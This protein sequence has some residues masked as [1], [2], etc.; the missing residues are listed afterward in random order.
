MTT[1][2]SIAFSVLA[3]LGFWGGPS[4]AQGLSWEINVGFS[5]AHKADAWTPIFV[6]IANTG[7][8]QQ[9]EVVIPVDRS[10]R[11][12][13]VVNYAIPVDAP[14]NSKKRYTLYLPSEGFDEAKLILTGG[15]RTRAIPPGP[16]AEPQD[17]LAVVIGGDKGLLSFLT[18]VKAYDLGDHGA[19]QDPFSQSVQ[20]E[21]EIMV[22]HA[23]WDRLP[24]SWLGWDGVDA[25][26]LGDAL[27]AGA[28]QEALDALLQWVR[29]GGCLIVGGG[30]RSQEIANSPISPLLPF[31]VT[32][33]K[34]LPDLAELGR[35]V[36]APIPAQPVLAVEGE[37]APEAEVLCGTQEQPLIAARRVGLGRVV[38]TAFDYTAAPVKYWNG[39]NLM[40]PLLLAR[41]ARPQS[42][43]EGRETPSRWQWGV[44]LAEAATYAPEGRL[45]PVWV[46]LTFLGA[47]VVVLV[48]ANHY[49][50]HRMGRRELAWLTTP[51]I[52]ALFA[53]FAYALGY[54]IRGGALV[55]NRLSVIETEA[56][57]GLARGR[58]YVGIF[59]PGRKT[60][61]FL[62]SGSAIGGR[63][64][65]PPGQKTHT[66]ASVYYG[67]LP[68]IADV[69]MNMWTSRA[70]G[71][72]F[73]AD[74][75]EGIG[76]TIEYDG[77]ALRAHVQNNTGFPLT[78]CRLVAGRSQ[79]VGKVDIMP[80][81]AAD[82]VLAKGAPVGPRGAY[83]RYRGAISEQ[84]EPKAAIVD[85]AL[86]AVFGDYYGMSTGGG[87]T[88]AADEVYVLALAEE[89]L[90]PVELSERTPRTN[91]VGIIFARL[92]TKLA[93]GKR[94]RVPRYLVSTQLIA[95]ENGL[96]YVG[97]DEEGIILREGTSVFE[98]RVPSGPAGGRATSLALRAPLSDPGSFVTQAPGPGAAPAP[99]GPAP[100][101]RLT[102]VFAYDFPRDR[103]VA[104]GRAVATS[105][106]AFPQPASAYMSADGR[107]LVKLT[108]TS[109]EARFDM[110]ALEA[111]VETFGGDAGD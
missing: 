16:T 70:F 27:F 29:L 106:L 19:V 2:R 40:W 32:G 57:A 111:E 69:R 47:Y 6:D 54:G 17:T 88:A 48:P 80:G 36:A 25:V 97:P 96:G 35:W 103:W 83:R 107:V 45:P 59:S 86:S 68:R 14:R 75:G 1:W 87:G 42:L 76:G 72:D 31:R 105:Q 8:S 41:T 44:T 92:P 74:V 12:E 53:V 9:G 67:A 50:L 28:S 66:P 102:E 34:T 18:G 78:Q 7:D 95:S 55:L 33:T 60:Y 104:I 89:P 82:L 46:I 30:A 22:G 101:P 56:D 79:G 5:G 71:V 77:A 73:L 91:D 49:L 4:H 3:L 51:V 98:F 63:D 94:M 39:Q 13:Q 81:E 43:T 85:L 11:Q 109:G 26:I 65:V 110:L 90:I 62:L 64:L 23:D 10:G 100:T 20:R 84:T 15:A 38:L 58:G 21:A 108:V 61:Q 24:G 52:V 37:L 93:P 99:S